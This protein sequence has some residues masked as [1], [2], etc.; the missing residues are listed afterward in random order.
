MNPVNTWNRIPPTRSRQGEGG[1]LGG[2]AVHLQGLA[3]LRQAAWHAARLKRRMWAWDPGEE[4]EGTG[5]SWHQDPASDQ[6]KLK[7]WEAPAEKANM[8]AQRTVFK[9]H[10]G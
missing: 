5:R 7:P 10:Q 6:S 9:H 8:D 4:Q 2:L 1:T 3:G